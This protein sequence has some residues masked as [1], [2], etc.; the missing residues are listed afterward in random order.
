LKFTLVFDE[1]IDKS[2]L[3]KLYAKVNPVGI[4]GS[5]SMGGVDKPIAEEMIESDKE[6]E[7]DD[8]A[9]DDENQTEDKLES[10]VIAAVNPSPSV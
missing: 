6:S 9:S 7:L 5:S 4:A 10:L 2:E 3:Q 1:D 8:G